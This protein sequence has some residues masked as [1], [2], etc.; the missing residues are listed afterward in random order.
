MEKNNVVRFLNQFIKTMKKDLKNIGII[1]DKDGT[2][3]LNDV[4]KETLYNFKEKNLGV[5]VYIIANSGRTIKDMI[6][7]LEQENIPTNYF[8]YII[9]DNGAMCLD[10]KTNKQ[11]YKHI[12]DKDVVLKVI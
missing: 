10:V 7:C 6:N 2:I 5:N 8:D 11:L 12:I 9:G 3:L 1:T 4:L